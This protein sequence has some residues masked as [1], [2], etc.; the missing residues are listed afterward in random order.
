MHVFSWIFLIPALGVFLEA[1][2]MDTADPTAVL[3][4][5]NTDFALDLYIRLS[6]GE[7]NCFVSPLSI[8]C[9]LAMT[10][11]GAEGETARQ[12]AKALHLVL[13]PDQL[14]AAFHRLFAE[15][16]GRNTPL[17]GSKEPADVQL[18]LANALWLQA[19]ERILPDFQKRIQVNYQG[20]LYPVDFQ[21][22]T[23]EA[24]RRI[25]AWVE[26]QTKG[27]IQDLLKP[28]HVTTQTRLIL[29]NAIYFKALWAL[30]FAKEHTHSGD[31]GPG[32]GDRGR[33]GHGCRHGPRRV[34]RT[35]PHRLPGRPPLF[36]PDP[37]PAQ[38]Q[39]PV[40]RTADQARGVIDHSCTGSGSSPGLSGRATLSL[41]A[42]T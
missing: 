26:E 40:P 14:H 25:N 42:P 35:T 4:R 28:P 24:R 21:T 7:G 32:E 9:A 13:P 38:R 33:R 11:A 5:G 6:Q 10:Y 16:H 2:S 34:G 29:T 1:S 23:E 41:A 22:G 30:P 3:V 12:M 20:G 27:K 15:L 19:G 39:H 31:L 18:F 36:V 37:R 17:P 8:S